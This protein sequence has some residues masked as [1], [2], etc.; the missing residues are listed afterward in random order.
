MTSTHGD[1]FFGHKNAPALERCQPYMAACGTHAEHIACLCP[2][3]PDPLGTPW[4]QPQLD[5]SP[6]SCSVAMSP[7][8]LPAAS[9]PPQLQ[10]PPP[11]VP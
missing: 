9:L 1:S 6:S 4:T 10:H 8:N 7:G 3:E 11:Q 5:P 2:F